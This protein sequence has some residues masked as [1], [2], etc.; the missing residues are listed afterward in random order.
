VK[1]KSDPKPRQITVLVAEPSASARQPSSS[2]RAEYLEGSASDWLKDQLGRVVKP[3]KI[4]LD[5]VQREMTR[6]QQDMDG[7]LASVKTRTAGGYELTQVQVMV[8]V[9]AQGSIA[10]VTA[11]VQASLTLVY[12]RPA[13]E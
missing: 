13:D 4:A 10:V 12:S 2:Q 8:G 6:F 1:R 9:S 11:G 5:K 7:L 3:K